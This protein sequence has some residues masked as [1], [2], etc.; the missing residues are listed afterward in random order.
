[1]FWIF[2][3]ITLMMFGAGILIYFAYSSEDF[4]RRLAPEVLMSIVIVL[5]IVIMMALLFAI[6][7]GFA[8][9]RLANS[10][11]ALGLPEGS[12]RAMI[13]LILIL[14]F[15]IFGVYLFRSVGQGD[16]Q[17]PTKLEAFT[18][19]VELA[20]V[21]DVRT[22]QYVPDPTGRGNDYYEVWVR[23]PVDDDGAR[24]AQQLITTV[25]TLVVAVAGFYFGSSTF[26]SGV[27]RTRASEDRLG[28]VILSFSPQEGR[29]HDLVELK[30]QG[31]NLRSCQSISLVRDGE[32]LTNERDVIS[33]DT[34]AT[35]YIRLTANPGG[36]KWDL[37]VENENG[38]QDIL[39]WTFTINP[40]E[41]DQ[42]S[43][44]FV[45]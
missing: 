42:S 4:A 26:R 23:T 1:M 2:T 29:Q 44:T 17:G 6:A 24:L 14:V 28:P 20:E 12:I 31:R 13:A 5:G 33:S 41:G 15:I 32:Q 27:D 39:P 45:Q 16:W 22:V 11:H 25:G 35:A 30:V 36:D 7:A 9:M 3:F 19:V 40:R 18:E 10:T 38:A 34:E 8:S 43:V 37:V 21:S